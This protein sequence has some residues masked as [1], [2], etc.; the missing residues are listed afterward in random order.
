MK[1]LI[2]IMAVVSLLI[3]THY[4]LGLFSGGLAVSPS[5]SQNSLDCKFESPAENVMPFEFRLPPSECRL[6]KYYGSNVITITVDYPSMEIVKPHRRVNDSSKDSS[7]VFWIVRIDMG[8]YREN[9]TIAWLSPISNREGIEVY[10]E[11]GGFKKFTARDGRSVFFHSVLDVVSV[12]RIFDC[13]F[14]VKYKYSKR[15]TDVKQMDE[16]ALG[17]LEKITIK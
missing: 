9:E 10:S 8:G 3:F 15:F 7:V 11:N 1:R 12:R 13:R 2:Y 17:L 5:P 6:V 16:F 4:G 14:L